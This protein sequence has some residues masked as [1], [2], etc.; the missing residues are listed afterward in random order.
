MLALLWA[1]S[2]VTKR[3]RFDPGAFYRGQL[4][5]DG[6][7][8]RSM[9]IQFR[10]N[11]S[12]AV[13][14]LTRASPRL[15][16]L[17]SATITDLGSSTCSRSRRRRAMFPT[18]RRVATSRGLAAA[19]WRSFPTSFLPVTSPCSIRSPSVTEL[20]SPVGQAF[21]LANDPC[22]LRYITSGPNP[23]NRARNCA[24]AGI[25]QPFSSNIVDF[26]EPVRDLGWQPK[27][28]ERNR[29]QLDGGRPDPLALRAARRAE[30]QLGQH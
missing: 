1:T 19:D 5:G 28:Q 16:C 3:A 18:Q 9:A 14:T 6:T 17:S 23:A 8:L 22:D 15:T 27:S 25:T 12:T 11:P 30:C 29:E 4:N 10:S 24:A 20:F 13:S 21:F 7:Y 26:T 2:T